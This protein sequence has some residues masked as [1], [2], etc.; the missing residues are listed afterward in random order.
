MRKIV[1]LI[2]ICMLAIAGMGCGNTKKQTAV[3]TI[4]DSG[5]GLEQEMI[6]EAEG[7]VVHTITQ[8][9]S[10]NLSV[11]TE[12]QVAVLSE[13][14]E[15][16]QEIYESIDGIVYEYEMKDNYIREKIIID[17]TDEKTKERLQENQLLVIEGNE[18]KIS[19]KETVKSLGTGWTVEMKEE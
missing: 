16:R 11:Y 4:S 17:L 5:Y 10:L 7:D 15:E 14:M 2:L 6:L 19:L 1:S 13:N 18:D 3:C 12:E 8:T 9:M